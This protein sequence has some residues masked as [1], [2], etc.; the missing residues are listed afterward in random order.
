MRISRKENLRRSNQIEGDWKPTEGD[1]EYFKEDQK[2]IE[3]DHKYT[4]A[5]QKPKYF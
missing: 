3:G 4:Q 1:H 2:R 5:C